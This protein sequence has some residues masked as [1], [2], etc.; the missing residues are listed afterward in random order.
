MKRIAN[1]LFI[2]T[3]GGLLIS[4]CEEIHDPIDDLARFSDQ[5]ANVYLELGATD[6]KA[7]GSVDLYVEYWSVDDSFNKLAF[8]YSLDEAL[9]FS[10]TVPKAN[11]T[12]TM[13]SAQLV[14]ELAEVLSFDHDPSSYNNEKKS[15]VIN[16]SFGVSYLL[17]P[18]E[19]S[20]PTVFNETL[21]NRLFPA[22]VIES[23]YEGFYDYMYQVVVINEN[24][25]QD[26]YDVLKSVLVK[27]SLGMT[28]ET[29]DTY[30]DFNEVTEGEEVILI[31]T[32]KQDKA[33]ELLGFI[34][35]E[36]LA[37]LTYDSPRREYG[38]YYYKGYELTAKFKV[39]NGDNI[40]NYS[41]EKTVKVL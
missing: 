37:D 20:N 38:L 14:R 30:F 19:L 17:A 1:F 8:M 35:D 15:Y 28:A 7:G 6:V 22:W 25:G 11:Y 13:D 21:V 18:V 33:V 41:E 26:E 5:A 3:L 34:R 36:S 29:F 23:F 39:V 4:S 9:N 2:L 10:I 32:V 27:D 31:P 24:A 12:Y 16:G 40:V